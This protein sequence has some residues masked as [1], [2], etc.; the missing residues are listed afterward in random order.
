MNSSARSLRGGRRR[1]ALAAG[2]IGFAL[3]GM[4][5]AP[6]WAADPQTRWVDVAA[7]A[8]GPGTG[9][10]A[11]A[12]YATITAAVT[13]AVSG[14]TIRVCAGSYEESLNVTKGGLKFVG[15]QAGVSAGVDGVR[16]GETSTGESTIVGTF[17]FRAPFVTVDGFEFTG[18][19][20]GIQTYG[21]GT[22][23]SVVN[24]RFLVDGRGYTA[25]AAI[26]TTA[27]NLFANG[28]WGVHHDSNTTVGGAVTGNVFRNLSY[29]VS[30]SAQQLTIRGNVV[31]QIRQ[32]GF[33]LYGHDLVVRDNEIDIPATAGGEGAITLTGSS[34]RSEVRGNVVTGAKPA[35]WVS[36]TA[37]D[38]TIAGNRLLT[39][40]VAVLRSGAPVLTVGA[41]WWGTA[42]GP[43][44]EGVLDA[45]RVTNVAVPRWCTD[46]AC[47]ATGPAPKAPAASSSDLD[48]ELRKNPNYAP[49]GDDFT[50][51]GGSLD[52]VD[53][54]KPFTGELAWDGD[55]DENVEVW[56]YSKPV[57]LGT[58][59]VVNGVVQI[60]GLDLKAL[61]AGGHRLVFVGESSGRVRVLAITVAGLAVTGPADSMPLLLAGGALVVVGVAVVVGMRLRRRAD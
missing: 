7:E 6:A 31:T 46:A 56:G 50:P 47:T 10:G 54:K 17:T 60:T 37:A 27:H 20:N 57:Y 13:A 29:A 36:A 59:P 19:G 49:A 12:A 28:G 4:S 51:S 43:H 34:A 30:S 1:T 35:V 14:D 58:F 52:A 38:V 23:E 25:Y 53:P 21:T 40:G 2:V 45:T 16:S 39:T 8:A 42:E 18:T 26:T 15:A 11:D 5:A 44:V 61:E 22:G 41:N 24:N 55:G 9:C 33:T 48:E 32:R 3:V